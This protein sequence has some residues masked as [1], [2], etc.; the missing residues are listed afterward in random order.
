MALWCG[1]GLAALLGVAALAVALAVSPPHL[2]RPRRLRAVEARGLAFERPRPRETKGPP[3]LTPLTRL[4]DIEDLSLTDARLRVALPQGDLAAG[5]VPL[6]PVRGG[7]GI[8]HFSG[9]GALT[10]RRKESAI[11]EG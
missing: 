7:G 10:L 5:R 11:A 2:G 6:N 3:D 9:S 1:A 8:R 4:F